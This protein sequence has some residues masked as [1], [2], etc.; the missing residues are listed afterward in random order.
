MLRL[1]FA[2]AAIMA[3]AAPALAAEFVLTIR[4]DSSQAVTRL[5]TFAVDADGEPVED[6]L[7]AIMEDI[8]AHSVG[9]LELDINRCQP[10]WLAVMLDEKDDLATTIDMCTSRT[11]VV[12]D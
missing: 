6:N 7:G 5:N 1:A 11:L 2:A 10:V 8:P 9:T 12:S 4:N 3:T